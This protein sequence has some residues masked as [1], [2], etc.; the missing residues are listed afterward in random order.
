[1]VDQFIRFALVGT[2]GFV[3]DVATLQGVM[4]L[5]GVDPYL[6]RFLSYLVAATC[7]WW[8]NRK[9][10]FPDAEQ[11]RLH[12][13]WARFVAV[14]GAGGVM[15]FLTYFVVLSVA[16]EVA[17]GPASGVAAGSIAGLFFNYTASRLWVFRPTT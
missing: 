9:F 5:A 6:G 3:V 10:T 13:Q 14:N 17:W 2:A 15:N 7:T 16:G 8:M 1:M 12:K 4:W 11:T